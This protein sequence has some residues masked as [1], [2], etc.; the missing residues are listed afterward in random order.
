MK[1]DPANI[2]PGLPKALRRLY[3]EV[4]QV[5]CKGLCWEACSL[6]PAQAIEVE[7]LKRVT[8]GDHRPTYD[9]TTCPFLDASHRC[10]GYAARPLICR[11][12]GA[13]RKMECPHG[14][15]PEGG[16]MSAGK[17]RE[18]LLKIVELGPEMVILGMEDG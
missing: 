2:D 1:T 11:M 8:G 4:P 14:C 10:S 17:E 16:F 7:Q 6:V 18:V 5:N 3:R 13:V 9:G 15:R 12:Y